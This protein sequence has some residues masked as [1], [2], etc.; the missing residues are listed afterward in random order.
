MKVLLIAIQD[1]GQQNFLLAQAMRDH[2]GWNA[3]SVVVKESYLGFPTDWTVDGNENEIKEFLEDVDLLIFQDHL[4]NLEGTKIKDIAGHHNTIITGTGSP[5]RKMVDISREDQ[6]H[7]WAIIPPISDETIATKMCCAP[8]ENV[9]VPI[10]RINEITAGIEKN[11]R[12]SV[13]HAPTKT[14][15]KGTSLVEATLKPY[16][17]SGEIEY[18]RIKGMSWEEALKAKA[19]CHIV[20]DS[21][22]A[23]TSSYGAGNA[24]E[25]LVLGQTVISKISPWCYALHP[26]LPMITT[27]GKDV[28]ETVDQEIHIQQNGWNETAKDFGKRW[29]KY[30][31]SA[32]NQIKHWMRYIEWVMTR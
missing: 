29:V 18:V 22:G 10:E 28:K 26:D 7:G 5:M 19:R 2:M 16:I 3:K 20:I 14:G 15:A 24:L 9:I 17:E 32:E 4:I 30:H 13:C 6:L 25:G 1:N 31:F 12:I 23:L 8:F 27:F 11:N 21:L